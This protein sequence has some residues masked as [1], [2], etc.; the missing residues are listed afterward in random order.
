MT[1][2]KHFYSRSHNQKVFFP[3]VLF[4]FKEILNQEQ[5]LQMNVYVFAV[6]TL[7]FLFGFVLFSSSLLLIRKQS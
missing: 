1:K 2:G 4:N 7:F 5:S 6:E 3:F